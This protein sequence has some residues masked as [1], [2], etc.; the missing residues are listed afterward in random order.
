MLFARHRSPMLFRPQCIE[1]GGWGGGKVVVGEWYGGGAVFTWPSPGPMMTWHCGV[2]TK[3]L[4]QQR[5]NRGSGT[6]H[7][8]PPHYSDVIM[9][10]VASQITQPFNADQRNHQSSASLAFVRRIHRCRVI[11]PHKE[12][13]TRKMFPFDDVIIGS[14]VCRFNVLFSMWCVNICI[15]FI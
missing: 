14:S 3:Q 8:L 11:S 1:P 6:F 4:R 12:P 13:V 15:L 2:R 7:Y 9:G 5:H 10:A